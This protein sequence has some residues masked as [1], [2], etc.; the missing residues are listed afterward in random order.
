MDGPQSPVATASR[1]IVNANHS[2]RI[3]RRSSPETEAEEPHDQD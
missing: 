2:H 3:N 1:E